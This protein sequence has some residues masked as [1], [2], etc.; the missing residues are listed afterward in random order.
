DVVANAGQ[1]ADPTAADQDDGVLLK[2]VALARDVGGYLDVVGQPDPRHLAEGGV[3]LL[4]GYDLA[5]GADPLLLGSAL[6][7]EGAWPGARHLARLADKLVDGWPCLRSVLVVRGSEGGPG[8]RTGRCVRLVVR[9]AAV[10]V[11]EGKVAGG[12]DPTR[13]ALR[14]KPS[15]GRLSLW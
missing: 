12:G 5:L 3:G 8:A 14:E 7:R 4:G 2:V 15:P 13:T 9:P 1:V 6:L 10:K 11:R